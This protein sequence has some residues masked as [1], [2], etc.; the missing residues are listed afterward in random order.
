MGQGD[1]AGK[2]F[3]D[4]VDAAKRID[5]IDRVRCAQV[6]REREIFELC[7]QGNS[8]ARIAQQLENSVVADERTLGVRRYFTIAGREPFDEE[9]R[10]RSTDDDGA[11]SFA[12]ACL[13]IL[14]FA[15]F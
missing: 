2:E 5:E 6:A 8:T 7:I 11:G 1:P 12:G 14:R 3:D 9:L 10:G 15:P 4:L 13:L